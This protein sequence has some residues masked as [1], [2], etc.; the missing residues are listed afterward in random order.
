MELTP[1]TITHLQE[2]CAFK[3]RE[4]GFEDETLH[5]RLVLLMEEVGELARAC[6]KSSGM[7]VDQARKVSN[8]TG[9]E[10]ADVLNLIFAVGI[11]LGLDIEKEFIEKNEEV[12]KRVYA[13]SV[14]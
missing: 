3:I 8:L 7:N 12:D 5:E 1:G 14:S 9:E 2:Y 6:R 4:R 13:R 11:Q 10:V